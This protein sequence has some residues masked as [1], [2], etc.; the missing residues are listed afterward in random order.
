MGLAPWI[1]PQTTYVILRELRDAECKIEEDTRLPQSFCELREERKHWFFLGGV[2]S[3][4]PARWKER[5]ECD[6][7]LHE[8]TSSHQFPK[9]ECACFPQQL[10]KIVFN[11]KIIWTQEYK[12]ILCHQMTSWV[13]PQSFELAFVL[14]TLLPS[15]RKKKEQRGKKTVY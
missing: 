11:L 10:K 7:V 12:D 4:F 5:W 1:S 6:A 9:L 14:V 3:Y 8:G 13:L 2:S 15:S